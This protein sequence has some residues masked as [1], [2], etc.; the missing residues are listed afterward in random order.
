[1]PKFR[2][3]PD[4]VDRQ[5]IPDVY[6]RKT[7]PFR[8]AGILN[9]P[10]GTPGA[11][12][13][14]QLMPGVDIYA[15]AITQPGVRPVAYQ[16][17]F[18]LTLA[19]TD[20]PV[21]IQAGTFQCDAILVDVPSS[22]V[23]SA[24]FGFGGGVTSASGIEIRPGIP[25]FFSPDNVREQ[26]EIQRLLETIT[27]L[28]GFMVGL[29]SGLPPIPGPGKFMAPRVVMNA[30]DYYVVNATGITQTIAVMLFTVPEYQ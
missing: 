2:Y 26:W 18:N 19:V 20:Q 12:P 15:D 3:P 27:A 22:S 8:Q 28:M 9:A 1:M 25:Q 23:N 16:R 11:G 30:H 4:W 14:T 29:Q 7:D 6:P 10:A 17:A 5:V 24:F 13:D 21:A